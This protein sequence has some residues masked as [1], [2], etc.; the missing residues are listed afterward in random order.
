MLG[1][2]IFGTIFD[3]DVV[4]TSFAKDMVIFATEKNIS[5]FPTTTFL[6]NDR[7]L[8][9]KEMKEIN[10]RFKNRIQ[11]YKIEEFSEEEFFEKV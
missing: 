4:P 8:F 5:E 6:G 11:Q 3:I 7:E 2:G 10:D 1:S 9:L